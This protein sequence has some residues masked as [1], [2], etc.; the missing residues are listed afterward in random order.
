MLNN[1]TI[2]DKNSS[3]S[4]NN[5]NRGYLIMSYKSTT[6]N[7]YVNRLFLS[8]N[9][10][11]HALHVFIMVLLPFSLVSFCFPKPQGTSTS[12]EKWV[13]RKSTRLNSSHANISY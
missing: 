13:D 12:S 6:N 3:N 10:L 1:H 9:H 11:L 4:S 2:N 5:K 8:L 7:I